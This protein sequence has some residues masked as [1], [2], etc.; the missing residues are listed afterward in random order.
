MKTT[1]S[2]AR[3]PPLELSVREPPLRTRSGMWRLYH[4]KPA[5]PLLLAIAVTAAMG[6]HTSERPGG[7]PY[8]GAPRSL[9][10][11]PAA[12]SLQQ[13]IEPSTA[14]SHERTKP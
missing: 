10:E 3:N 2:R 1:I 13:E 4:L 8:E 12:G 6:C 5:I 14:A 7:T 11:A 9:V